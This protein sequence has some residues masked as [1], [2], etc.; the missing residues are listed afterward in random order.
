MGAVSQNPALFQLKDT[1]LLCTVRLSCLTSLTVACV[2]CPDGMFSA[3]QHR[4]S[5]LPCIPTNE[6]CLAQRL[7]TCA[8]ALIW[9]QLC[10]VTLSNPQLKPTTHGLVVT[11]T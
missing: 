8:T 2:T 3:D 4:I 11:G 6:S 1:L 10:E 5:P 7:P 9:L